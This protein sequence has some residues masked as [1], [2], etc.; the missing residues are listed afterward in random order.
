MD[1][2]LDELLTGPSA[3]PIIVKPDGTFETAAHPPVRLEDYAPEMIDVDWSGDW[4]APDVL[5]SHERDAIEFVERDTGWKVLTG[6]AQGSLFIFGAGQRHFGRDLEEHIRETPGLW[7]RV[8]VD[9]NPPVCDAG[10]D[11]M[12]CPAWVKRER[13]EHAD[14]PSES[15]GVGWALMHKELPEGETGA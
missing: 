9:V 8:A 12:P 14:Y 4:D 10:D 1:E 3:L 15:K 11:G 13:C 6:W 5:E 7:A 2:T